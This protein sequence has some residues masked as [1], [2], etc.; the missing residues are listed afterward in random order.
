MRRVYF[1]LFVAA[2]AVT[3][4]CMW[5]Q[6]KK[7]DL[8]QPKV[9]EFNPPPDEARYNN[10]PEDKYRKPPVSKDLASKPGAMGGG[11]GGIGPSMPPGGGT[12]GR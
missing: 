11:G 10:P 3:T 4:G 5:N 8:K 6:T 12:G 2:I 7:F 9:E 1:V